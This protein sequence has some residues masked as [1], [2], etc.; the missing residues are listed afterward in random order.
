[1]NLRTAPALQAIAGLA[2]SLSLAACTGGTEDTESTSDTS[3]TSDSTGADTDGPDASCEGLQ[4]PMLDESSCAPLGTDYTPRDMMSANDGWD[5]CVSDDAAYHL[6]ETTPSSIARAEAYEDIA[7][8]LWRNGTPSKEDFTAARD[9]YAIAEGLGSRL[10]RR[11]DL[12]YP[13]IPMSDW[14]PVVDPDKQ[15]TV[16]ENT[17]KYPDRCA[18][19]AKL[20][21]I[22]TDAFAAG[23]SGEG[24]PDIHAARIDA[25]FLWFYYISTYKEANTCAT[26]VAK[27]CDSSWGYYTGGNGIDGGI[28]LAGLI[29]AASV[30]S[31]N[32]I[33]DGLL[34]VRCWRDLTQ[35][36]GTYPL[37]D[38]LPAA[39]QELFAQ[40]W[41]QLD[42]AL[43]RGYARMLRA[44][45]A[46][47]TEDKCSGAGSATH[48]AFLQIAGPVLDREAAERG[49]PEAPSLK[50]L[51]EM[52]SP[53]A[54]DIADG[55]AALDAIFPCG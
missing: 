52:D 3:D 20:T 9:I 33:W 47:M 18:G 28:A 4:L 6:V 44:R 25:A 39:D 26:V 38:E 37:L 46:K 51:W 10:E 12:H 19:P 31:H 43:H 48:W 21:P 17:T 16:G 7:D 29:R 22:V 11:E 13:E 30:E 23:Q 41:E 55:M 5:A 53:T 1:M 40:G 42:Q 54:Q 15:C 24:D 50:A 49:A 34:A 32:R 27:D 8:L 45:M 2:L 14:D 36:M 35:D